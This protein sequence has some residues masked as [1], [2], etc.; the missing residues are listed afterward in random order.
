MLSSKQTAKEPCF[1]LVV[2][3]RA[4]WCKTREI[5]TGSIQL[6]TL[7]LNGNRGD[8]YFRD[9]GLFARKTQNVFLCVV[10]VTGTE[11]LNSSRVY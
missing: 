11:I 2:V 5:W 6:H 10:N 7:F 9:K 3:L 4:L 1:G 8:T